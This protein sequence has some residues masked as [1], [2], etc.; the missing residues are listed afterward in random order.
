MT[1]I[2]CKSDTAERDAYVT[3]GGGV[4][5]DWDCLAEFYVERD[6]SKTP[7]TVKGLAELKEQ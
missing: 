2:N 1:C 3:Y 5:C 4:F 6:L 7:E